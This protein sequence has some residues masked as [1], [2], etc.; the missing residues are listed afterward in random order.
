MSKDI[1]DYFN[2]FLLS[3]LNGENG[4]LIAE[5]R[6]EWKKYCNTTIP[7]PIEDKEPT[8]F[9]WDREPFDKFEVA[10]ERE[11][12]KLSLDN[13]SNTPDFILAEFI[14][15]MLE[16]F[17][18]AVAARDKHKTPPPLSQSIP[19]GTGTANETINE[20]KK[21]DWHG[22]RNH[23]ITDNPVLDRQDKKER[24]EVTYFNRERYDSNAYGFWTSKEIDLSKHKWAIKQAIEQVLNDDCDEKYW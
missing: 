17:S 14:R 12:N 20:E 5:L 24:I 10:V 1:N 22:E 9:Q 21:W 23:T 15:K 13:Q 2:D 7:K 3:M 11:V 19:A 4:K 6:Y 8:A 16:L 18:K